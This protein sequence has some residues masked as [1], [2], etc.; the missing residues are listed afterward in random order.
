MFTFLSAAVD[1]SDMLDIDRDLW[2][3]PIGAGA[4]LARFSLCEGRASE[5]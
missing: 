4:Q 2:L 5:G 1:A 3:W